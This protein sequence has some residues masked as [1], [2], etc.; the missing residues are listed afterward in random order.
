[1]P[2]KPEKPEELDWNEVNEKLGIEVEIRDDLLQ[3]D[4][5][6]YN[7]A[8]REHNPLGSSMLVSAGER[9]GLAVR[10]A[11][12]AGWFEKLEPPLTVEDVA[13]TKPYIVRA[14]AAQVDKVY[15]ALID[16]PPN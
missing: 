9:W 1:M 8:F 5:E 4:L 2:E 15:G 3:K 16:I 6:A 7:A 12:A 11:I 10:A 14:I 13:T